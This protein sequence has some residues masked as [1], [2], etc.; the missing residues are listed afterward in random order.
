MTSSAVWRTANAHRYS[1]G[2]RSL[3]SSLFW[4]AL[5]W[6]GRRNFYCKMQDSHSK[7]VQLCHPSVCSLCPTA[8]KHLSL[9]TPARPIQTFI[10]QLGI[11]SAFGG[12]QMPQQLSIATSGR[13]RVTSKERFL[14]SLFFLSLVLEPLSC[15]SLEK[16]PTKRSTELLSAISP[17]ILVLIFKTWLLR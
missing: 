6:H 2:L 13:A 11:V 8:L 5:I 4:V 7:N 14:V 3:M 16:I 15:L 1:I 9:I 10:L 12:M 17:S